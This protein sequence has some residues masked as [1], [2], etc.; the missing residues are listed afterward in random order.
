MRAV[1]WVYE[2]SQ[3]S[4]LFVSLFFFYVCIVSS[5]FAASKVIKINIDI[6][7]FISK[8]INSEFLIPSTK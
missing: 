8:K 4:I 3:W 2:Q 5:R 6:K 7:D 1:G